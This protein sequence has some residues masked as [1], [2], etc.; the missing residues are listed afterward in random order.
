MKQKLIYLLIVLIFF[1]LQDA[2]RIFPSLI[3]NSLLLKFKWEVTDYGLFTA[4]YY[5]GYSGSHIPVSIALDKYGLKKTTTISIIITS[6]GVLMLSLTN[7]SFLALFGRFIIGLGSSVAFLSVTKVADQYFVRKDL[8]ISLA[9]SIGLLGYLSNVPMSILLAKNYTWESLSMALT[10]LTLLVALL[11]FF[12]LPNAKKEKTVPFNSKEFIKIISNKKIILLAIVNF[13]MV[14]ALE[15]FSD[16][17]G[18][19]YLV[20]V[21]HFDKSISAQIM[22]FVFLGLLFG[23]PILAFLAKKLNYYQI[24]VLS[25][26]VLALSVGFF[27]LVKL[28][29]NQMLPLAFIIGI[30]SCYQIPIIILG[31]QIVKNSSLPIGILNSINMLGGAFFHW[32][33]GY[34]L[35]ILNIYYPYD[36]SFSMALLTIPIGSLLGSFLVFFIKK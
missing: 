2:L 31:N 26:F 3:K 8:V 29:L 33:V 32:I 28:S 25:G 5:L 35:N 1:I 13:L 6:L 7:S 9:F 30:F 12:T 20:E 17:W 11:A 27:P 36:I 19:N 16:I 15:G 22:S 23:S 4:L 34:S 24:L 10:L 21:Y 18:L 14:G